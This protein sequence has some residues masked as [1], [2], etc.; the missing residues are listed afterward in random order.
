[1]KW[2]ECF[3]L[4]EALLQSAAGLY[5]GSWPVLVLQ[6]IVKAGQQR[7]ASRGLCQLPWLG[8]PSFLSPWQQK[9]AARKLLPTTCGFI[10]PCSPELM[11]VPAVQL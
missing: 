3:N 4:S 5:C 11:E 9:Y 7:M 8:G 2:G 1:M 6:H 10:L